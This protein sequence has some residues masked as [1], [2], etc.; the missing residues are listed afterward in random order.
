MKGSISEGLSKIDISQ[1][2]RKDGDFLERINRIGLAEGV[3]VCMQCG[4][5][6]SSCPAARFTGYN[7]RKIIDDVR[8]GDKRVLKSDEIWNC[9]LCDSCYVRCP[10]NV[11]PIVLILILR[12][13]ALQEGYGWDLI[14]KM[15]RYGTDLYDEGMNLLPDTPDIGAPIDLLKDRD[16]DN[17]LNEM[18]IEKRKVSKEGIGELRKILDTTG[19]PKRIESLDERAKNAKK[20][21]KIYSGFEDIKEGE[22]G[23]ND[24]K[25][26]LRKIFGLR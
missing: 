3:N 16:M 10:R 7:I 25:R 5:C 23:S 13:L 22:V 6:T 12:M 11:I 14:A 1:L 19:Y 17:I 15:K 20:R 18:G 26:I 24:L 4:I 9:S 21:K 2:D 8:R